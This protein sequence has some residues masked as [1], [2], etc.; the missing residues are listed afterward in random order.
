MFF[1]S[2]RVWS[3][4]ER[5]RLFI[6]NYTNSSHFPILCLIS[7]APPQFVSL[8]I[9]I[10]AVLTLVF[11]DEDV[12][13]GDH[14]EWCASLCN[15]ILIFKTFSHRFLVFLLADWVNVCSLGQVVG[16]RNPCR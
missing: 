9:F 4:A 15:F 2:E 16:P 12:P 3:P 11:G 6:I 7:F 5:V 13:A 14:V 1:F 10:I 8:I